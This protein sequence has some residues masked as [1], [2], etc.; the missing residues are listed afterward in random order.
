MVVDTPSKIDL[1]EL[2]VETDAA[3]D[4]L[5]WYSSRMIDLKAPPPGRSEH[6][7]FAAMM[8]SELAELRECI[9]KERAADET[10]A[11]LTHSPAPSAYLKL[12]EQNGPRQRVDLT[13]DCELWLEALHPI[14]TP[15]YARMPGVI[16]ETKAVPSAGPVGTK[17]PMDT[18][19]GEKPAGGVAVKA[20]E[21]QYAGD[22]DANGN[23]VRSDD[24]KLR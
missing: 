19:T 11:P 1:A 16:H 24:G 4:E 9:A 5:E 6:K 14:I 20:S 7:T 2:R 22:M 3:I 23:I 12:W 21:R 10:L 17:P 15:L 13:S 8:Q 18:A